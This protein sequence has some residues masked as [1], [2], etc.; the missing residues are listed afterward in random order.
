MRLFALTRFERQGFKNTMQS[1]GFDGQGPESTG[2]KTD[3]LIKSV[4]Y[5]KSLFSK[6]SCIDVF[7]PYR[8]P[9][10]FKLVLD[11]TEDSGL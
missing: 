10:L 11:T 3:S 9:I 4:S 5:L 7:P 1:T 8:L 2:V 6:V